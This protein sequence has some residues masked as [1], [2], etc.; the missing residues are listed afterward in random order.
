MGGL[1]LSEQ[2][3]RRTVWGR[4]EKRWAE[5]MEREEGGKTGIRM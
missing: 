1:S 3:D 2:K 4:A 5:E